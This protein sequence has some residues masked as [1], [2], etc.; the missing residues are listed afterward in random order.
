MTLE[1]KTNRLLILPWLITA[2]V[3]GYLIWQT[4]LVTKDGPLY[5]ERAKNLCVSPREVIAGPELGYPAMILGT[6]KVVE[7][8]GCTDSPYEWLIPTQIMTL[9][10]MLIAV[11][12]IYQLGKNIVGKQDAFLAILILVFLPYPMRFAA[13]IIRDWPSIM[14]FMT[15]MTVLF[16]SAKKNSVLLFGLVGI[17][18][19]AG[20]LIR[21]ENAQVVIYGLLWLG[22]CFFVKRTGMDKR[23][24]VITAI[25]LLVCFAAMA[26]PYMIV[27]GNVLPEKLQGLISSQNTEKSAELVNY[28]GIS[29]DRLGKSFVK[30]IERI[31][32]NLMYYFF[33]FF[34]IG[35]YVRIKYQKEKII[36]IEK[37]I[38]PAFFTLNIMMMVLLYYNHGYMS[39]RHC[40]AM[41]I[42]SLFYVPGGLRA[43]AI[44]LESKFGRKEED[45]AG[46][47]WLAILLIIGI[48][49]CLPKLLAAKRADRIGFL[50]T[51]KWLSENTPEDAV[52]MV[53][54]FRVS[55]YADRTGIEG[56]EIKDL[57]P[58]AEYWVR[59]IKADEPVENWGTKLTEFP[60]DGKNT[61]EMVTI[62]KK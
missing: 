33:V 38:V 50:D 2:I 12:F 49:I 60:L 24:A 58:Q 55:F 40:L 28:A 57:M 18:S 53:P 43:A 11:L 46:R 29:G 39:R 4:C 30:I 51:A 8:F 13:D 62:H 56:W 45:K 3:G 37:V 9:C 10:C 61:D 31:S 15:A 32:E 35:A 47:F 6:H 54:D 59:V 34:V 42:V 14:I 36:D 7:I 1:T 20:Y 22:V 48:S 27:K 25:A 41:S 44:M 23:K 52:I 5:I 26:V 16:I 21:A 19:G 17:L